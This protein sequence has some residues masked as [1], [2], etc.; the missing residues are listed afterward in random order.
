MGDGGEGGGGL[1]GE[2]GEEEAGDV[3]AGLQERGSVG[4]CGWSHWLISV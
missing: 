1:G 4:D 3:E 2:E